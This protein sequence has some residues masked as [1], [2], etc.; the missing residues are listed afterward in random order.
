MQVSGNGILIL[1]VNKKQKTMQFA[2]QGH[3]M[4][5]ILDV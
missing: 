1:A 2:A 5:G 4:L 3:F